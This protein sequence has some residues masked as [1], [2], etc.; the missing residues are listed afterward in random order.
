MLT[1]PPVPSGA[2][3]QLDT[4]PG[5][6]GKRY[7]VPVGGGLIPGAISIFDEGTLVST[8]SSITQ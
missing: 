6:P 8:A 1:S 7:W 3:Y 4:V 5:Y 2:Q